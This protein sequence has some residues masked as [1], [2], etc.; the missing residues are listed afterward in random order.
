[1]TSSEVDITGALCNVIFDYSWNSLFLFPLEKAM[2]VPEN[3]RHSLLIY[4]T[5]FPTREMFK[6]KTLYER[7]INISCKNVMRDSS[8][9]RETLR[10]SLKDL[11]WP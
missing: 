5:D 4:D 6:T 1:M 7:R 8:E 9:G 10:I 2:Y 3:V 11:F